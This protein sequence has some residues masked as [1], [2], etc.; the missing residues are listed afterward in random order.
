LVLLWALPKETLASQ[1]GNKVEKECSFF[2][3][4]SFMPLLLINEHVLFLL[5][6]MWVIL[7]FSKYM[8]FLSISFLLNN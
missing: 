3:K 7:P 5:F 2:T 1:I 6:Y 4:M 8:S